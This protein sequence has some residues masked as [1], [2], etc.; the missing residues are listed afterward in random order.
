MRSYFLVKKPYFIL[1]VSFEV[2]GCDEITMKKR[3]HFRIEKSFINRNDT[4]FF[5]EFSFFSK[6]LSLSL[7]P[8]NSTPSLEK[9][10]QRVVFQI[11]E[12]DRRKA[13]LLL[14]LLAG[15][16]EE[17]NSLFSSMQLAS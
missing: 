13:C 2:V 8:F 15:R 3:R 7:S 12:R 10:E 17:K 4:S 1:N 14:C 16:R 11:E 6:L 5:L 9:S